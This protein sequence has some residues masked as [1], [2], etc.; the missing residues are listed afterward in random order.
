MTPQTESGDVTN[1]DIF[2]PAKCRK[3]NRECGPGA[4][5]KLS[6]KTD[7]KDEKKVTHGTGSIKNDEN[8][9][10]DD[11]YDDYD[12][13]TVII[14]ND[15]NV[16]DDDDD[17]DDDDEEKVIEDCFAQFQHPP[18]VYKVIFGKCD[19]TDEKEESLETE[20]KLINDNAKIG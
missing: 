19:N 18:G 6:L 4:Q 15:E 11:D 14:E 8:V 7:V 12:D 16:S 13:D 2:S 17:D 1:D 20:K 5:T 3:V 9:S 10:D